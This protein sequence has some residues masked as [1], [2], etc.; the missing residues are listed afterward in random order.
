MALHGRAC[1]L[2]G[3]T[4]PSGDSLSSPSH[5]AQALGLFHTLCLLSEIALERAGCQ[6]E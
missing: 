3:F 5:L 1:H 4:V 6:V 2:Q